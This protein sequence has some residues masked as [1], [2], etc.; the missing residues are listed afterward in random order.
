[1]DEVE[2]FGAAISGLQD[3]ADEIHMALDVGTITQRA[4]SIDEEEQDAAARA[5]VQAAITKARK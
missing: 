5:V 1:V 3:Y 4:R 2:D